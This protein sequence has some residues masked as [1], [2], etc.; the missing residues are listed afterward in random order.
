MVIDRLD[1]MIPSRTHA[2]AIYFAVQAAAVATIALGPG[3]PD[4]GEHR[5]YLGSA[6]IIDLLLAYGL[7][8]RSRFAW[9]A[10]VVLTLFGLMLYS[11]A[12][13]TI[14]ELQPKFVGV[15]LLMAAQLTLL[16]SHKLRPPLASLRRVGAVPC[17]DRS[18]RTGQ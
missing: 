16:Y 5:Q 7:Y 8:R 12:M 3:L 11:L 10:S 1:E 15:G 17:R 18:T 13:L 4:F 9:S 14:A 2:L 6:M